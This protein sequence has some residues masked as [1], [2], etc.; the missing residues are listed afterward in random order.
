MLTENQINYLPERIYERLNK[1]NSDCII[2]IGNVIK[3]IGELRP[4]DVHQLQQMYNY[5]ADIDK[6]VKELARA[7]EKNVSEIYEIFDIVAKDNYNY[8]KPFYKAKGIEY[9][10]YE[11]N[12]NLK[13]YV[14]SIAKQT[15][16]EYVNLTQHT[17]F[18]IF[19]QDGKSIAPLF[20]KNKNKIATSISDTYT[21]VIDYAVTKVQ[22]GTESYQSAMREVVKA[23]AN[24]GIK[25]VDYA[26][27]HKRR[28]ASAVRQNVLWGIKECNQNTADMIG[29]EFGA[30]G[31][32]IS[33]HSNPRP[34]HADM[35]GRQFARGKA[36]TVKGVYYPSFEEEAEPL[37]KEFG[38][39]HFKYSILLG[40]SPPAIKPE[41]LAE[42]KANDNKTFEFEGKKYTAYEGKQIMNKLE[43]S[44]KNYKDLAN[45]AKAS[46]DDVLRREVQEKINLITSKYHKISQASGLPT[47]AERMNVSGFRKVKTIGELKTPMVWISDNAETSESYKEYL[48]RVFSGN[49]AL[50][51]RHK[52]LFDKVPEVGNWARV[53]NHQASLEDLAAL[54]AFTGDE[55]AL[56]SARGYK[57]IYHGKRKR[58][59]IPN[60]VFEEICK[61]KMVWEGHSHPYSGDLMASPEDIKTLKLL[62]W[63]K[64]SSIIDV[65]GNTKT[66]TT[67][68]AD[69]INDMF[70]GG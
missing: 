2:S 67:R 37:L 9:K 63:Q 42:F 50:R 33:Y 22:L 12:E 35:G 58:W 25:T 11:E 20:E 45:A 32:E 61:K 69:V 57:I 36:R 21:K 3:E 51:R 65:E 1:V 34:S 17:A 43:S 70:G 19:S 26:T 41:Q 38:C 28:L 13:E 55:F 47:R 46:G 60:E 48:N 52:F 29:E 23:M 49:F 54:T 15:V 39:L 68:Y 56:F 30:D 16:D 24:S 64:K 31:Y 66:F 62:T 8:A 40:I 4:K 14:K 18:A 59:N 6:V 5:G 10:P 53:K 44:A 27:G 7:N